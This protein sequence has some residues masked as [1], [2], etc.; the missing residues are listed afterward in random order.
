MIEN[1]GRLARRLPQQWRRR[2]TGRLQVTLR[3]VRLLLCVMLLLVGELLVLHELH[4]H[5]VLL[6]VWLE[7]LLGVILSRLRIRKCRRCTVRI[8]HLQFTSTTTEQRRD[9]GAAVQC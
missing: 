9:T 4:V 7:L 6:G 1:L 3:R 5:E 8:L 2:P